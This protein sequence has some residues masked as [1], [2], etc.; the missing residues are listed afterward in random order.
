M[1]LLHSNRDM[2]IRNEQILPDTFT[3]VNCRW[4][5]PYEKRKICQDDQN[6]TRIFFVWYYFGLI[7]T[8]HKEYKDRYVMFLVYRIVVEIKSTWRNLVVIGTSLKW[9][10]TGNK[11]FIFSG[12]LDTFFKILWKIGCHI[13][14]IF[15]FYLKNSV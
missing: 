7:L 14:V 12:E 8:E 1:S 15:Q 4:S 9:N 13:L 6:S 3:I 2:H 10:K 5:G 11:V